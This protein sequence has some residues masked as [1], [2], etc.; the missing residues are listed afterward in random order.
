MIFRTVAGKDDEARCYRG[1]I[2]F[3]GFP[4]EVEV[5]PAW[6]EDKPALE[7]RIMPAGTE[8]SS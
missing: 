1:V 6:K 7:I 4:Y 8:K 2:D 5:Y 3:W